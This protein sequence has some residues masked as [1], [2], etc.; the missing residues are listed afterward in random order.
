MIRLFKDI[1]I[2]YYITQLVGLIILL[3][4]NFYIYGKTGNKL[5]YAIIIFI[6][7]AFIIMTAYRYTK[8]AT[9]R[10]IE[11]SN[12]ANNNKNIKEV[13]SSYEE[14]LPRAKNN[15]VKTLIVINLTGLYINLGETK[16]AMTLY[17][18]FT[19]TFDKTTNGAIN[20]IIYLNNICEICI[21]EKLLSLAKENLNILKKLIEN[22]N[23]DESTKKTVN[24]I[25]G[26][27]V[28]EL[29]FKENK[30][31]DYKSI[32]AYYL[33]R[34]DEEKS[35]ASKIF[36]AYQL[37]KVYKKLKNKK[38]EEKYKNYYKENRGELKYN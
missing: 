12:N 19:P 13:I 22:N 18:D 5:L 29:V 4:L 20:Q 23:F 33:K 14:I 7:L 21:R 27:L 6:T 3:S 35:S 38:E 17:K 34:F 37:S 11:L 31:K 1:N 8:K 36:F 10:I 15:K 9:I 25:Y 32:A 16:K 2:K 26:D 28:V 30:I 24:T